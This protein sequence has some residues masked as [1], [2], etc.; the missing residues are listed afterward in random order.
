MGW[1]NW[2]DLLEEDNKNECSLG[3][4]ESAAILILAVPCWAWDNV[5]SPTDALSEDILTQL[6][7]VLPKT[8]EPGK[9]KLYLSLVFSDRRVL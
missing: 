9:S 3:P 4:D 7:S 6:Q 5:L 1:E 8:K 2:E